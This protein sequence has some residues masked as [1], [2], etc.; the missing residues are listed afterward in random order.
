MITLGFGLYD[1]HDVY[2]DFNSFSFVTIMLSNHRLDIMVS[3]LQ[4][5]T[6]LINV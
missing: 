2:I 1:R 6:M 4:L 5:D 3:N